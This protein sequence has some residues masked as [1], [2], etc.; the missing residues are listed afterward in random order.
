[1]GGA[2]GGMQRRVG[3]TSPNTSLTRE[4]VYAD[5]CQ[6]DPVP[7]SICASRSERGTSNSFVPHQSP[8][9]FS[10]FRSEFSSGS[11][12]VS[13]SPESHRFIHTLFIP[14]CTYA[15]PFF[16]PPSTVRSFPVSLRHHFVFSCS[17]WNSEKRTPIGCR[18]EH[19]SAFFWKLEG[20]K[21]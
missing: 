21:F 12:V 3:V 14:V 9:E 10:V 6:L 8:S 7:P 1:M 11:F 17:L 19:F 4:V 15:S 16:L 5:N 18:T 20:K 13:C 2:L